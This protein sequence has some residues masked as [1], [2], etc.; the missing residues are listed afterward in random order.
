MPERESLYGMLA[1]FESPEALVEAARCAV[2]EGYRDLD[3]FTPFPV[4]ELTQVL[5]LEDSRV[6]WLGFCGGLFGFALASG[7]QLFTNFDYPINV[8]GRPTYALSAFA[9]V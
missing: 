3:A 8:G 2:A 7:M 1:E 4:E 9:V 6:L 5:R